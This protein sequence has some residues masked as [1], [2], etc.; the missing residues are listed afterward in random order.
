MTLVEGGVTLSGGWPE[1]WRANLELREA[2]AV[3]VRIATFRAMHLAQLDKRSRKAAV[4]RVFARR[5][6]G[7]REATCRK[8]KIYHA[9][10][11]AQRVADRPFA[12][13]WARRSATMPSYG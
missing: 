9:G 13:S 4:G 8:S 3:L 10:A 6:A 11:A 12:R 2:D 5:R 7:E 1:V